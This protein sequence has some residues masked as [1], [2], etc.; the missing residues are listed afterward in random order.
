MRSP[1]APIASLALLLLPTTALAAWPDDVSL[2]AMATIDG[3]PAGDTQAARSAYETVVRQL[4]VAIANPSMAPAETSGFNG[5]DVSLTS[6]VAFLD[7]YSAQG[8]SNPAPWERVQEDG[9]PSHAM[10]LPGINVRKGLPLSLEVGGRFSYVGFSRQAVVGG[11]GRWGL[12]EGYREW[13]DIVVQLG[14]SGYIGNDELELGVMDFSGSIGYTVPFGRVDGVN[15]ASFSPYIGGGL[16][17]INARPLMD[18]DEQQ[19]LGVRA[20][21]G[22]K[23]K[24]SHV[25]GYVPGAVHLGYR[26]QSGAFQ[27]LMSAAWAPNALPMLNTGVG[28]VY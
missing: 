15:E 6:S 9:D 24:D 1:L 21:S 16:Y 18:I 19:S 20:V 22:F 14:Y 8:S 27:L 7:A 3:Q 11:Y 25:E 26:L 10:W 5:F 17:V 28:Y 23:S 4:G 13:P 2:R 12:V